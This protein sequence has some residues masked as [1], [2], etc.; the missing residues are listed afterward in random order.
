M[1]VRFDDVNAKKG[2]LYRNSLRPKAYKDSAAGYY[3]LTMR[4]HHKAS[5]FG[6]IRD[7]KMVLNSLGR[8]AE[9]ELLS[10]PERFPALEVDQYVIK[11][12]HVHCIL[13]MKPEEGTNPEEKSYRPEDRRL[14]PAISSVIGL[15]KSGLSQLVRERYRDVVV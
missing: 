6:D 9:S 8:V 13:T 12:N 15:Y 4:A 3:T 5:R 2:L 7:G 14:F 11:P 1:D 10:I